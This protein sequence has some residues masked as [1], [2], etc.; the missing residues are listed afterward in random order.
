MKVICVLLDTL[1]RDHLGCY[2]AST[3]ETP[4][5]D[6]FAEESYQFD[7]AYLGSYPCMPAR[8][9]FWTGINNFFWRGW[10]PLEH[11]Q[12]DLVTMLNQADIPTMLITDHYHLWQNGSGNYHT[13]F[14]GMELIRGQEMDN[15]KIGSN[16]PVRYPAQKHKLNKNWEKYAKNTAHFETKED[17]FAGQVFQKSME[18]VEENKDQDDYFLMIDCFDPHEPFDPPEEF[19][20]KYA[21]D[22][23]GESP[24]WPRYGRPDSLSTEELHHVHDLYKAQVT[25]VDECFGKFYEKL[26]SLH[27]MEDTMVIVTSDHGFLFGEHSWLGK[28]ARIIY[29][30]IAR[31]PLLVREPN[32]GKKEHVSQLTQIAD[33]TPTILEAFQ[34]PK[35]ENMQGYDLTPVFHNAKGGIHDRK[36]M[37]FGVFG[38]PVYVTDGMYVLVK[39]PVDGNYPLY[40]YTKSHYQSWGFGQNNYPEQSAERLKYWDGARFPVQY[41]NAQPN[42]AAPLFIKPGEEKT[43]V[44]VH[45]DELYQIQEDH[46]Q[47]FNLIEGEEK[48]AQELMNEMVKEMKKIGVPE[49][50]YERL[51]LYPK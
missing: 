21:P 16:I 40:W 30:D 26:K 49:E 9:D 15:W 43:K 6:K 2:G 17:Y 4:N 45:K 32:N 11:H 34:L 8:Q 36:T 41:E 19:L 20:E 22:Y 27:D 10:S 31:I 12:F 48:K 51:G 44:Q 1:R 33:L 39:H 13:N 38:G 29:Q 24:K 7:N 5:L 47:E 42:H 25:Y 28:H 35:P 3:V 46:L 18:W 37:M 14:S 23:D 50:Q